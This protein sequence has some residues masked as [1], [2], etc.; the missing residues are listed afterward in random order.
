M[1]RTI[2]NIVMLP[3]QFPGLL[4][5]KK[6]SGGDHPLKFV[7]MQHFPLSLLK[8]PI[9]LKFTWLQCWLLFNDIVLPIKDI[10]CEDQEDFDCRLTYFVLNR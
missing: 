4:C 8:R 7:V 9:F 1:N 10:V 3:K 6:R 2:N 5:Q